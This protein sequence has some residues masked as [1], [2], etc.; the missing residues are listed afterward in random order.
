M[1]EIL[2]FIVV[3]FSVIYFLLKDR[4]KISSQKYKLY[5]IS[6][7]FAIV[8]ALLPTTALYNDG[9]IYLGIPVENFLYLN[10]D[11]VK[12]NPLGF[13]LNF[14]IF[15]WFLRLVVKIW[16]FLLGKSED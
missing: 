11:I 7:I 12:F 8:F 5:F 1:I 4:R 9:I 14:F 2:F 3:I 13:I 10:G 15:Y 16:G 6:L